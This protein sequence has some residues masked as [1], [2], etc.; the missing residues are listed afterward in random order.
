MLLR[1]G[2]KLEDKFQKQPWKQPKSPARRSQGGLAHLSVAL[3]ATDVALSTFLNVEPKLP[4][5][6]TSWIIVCS[7][8]VTSFSALRI[9]A[10]RTSPSRCSS[11]RSCG[12]WVVIRG[13][14]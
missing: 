10:S 12:V 2:S 1:D 11:S 14:P 3:S 7:K 9:L 4:L 13:G 6:V 5:A 8:A